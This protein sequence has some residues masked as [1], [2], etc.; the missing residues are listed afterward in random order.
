VAFNYRRF[1]GQLNT[2]DK[3]YRIL[4]IA[5]PYIEIPEQWDY[6]TIRQYDG[7]ITYNSK[8]YRDNKNRLNLKLVHGCMT[9]NSYY[10][11]EEFKS[12]EERIP[13]ACILNRSYNTG[14]E[15][16]IVYLRE[17]IANNLHHEIPVHIWSH[18]KWGGSKFKG[19][20]KSPIHHS[21]T[22]HLK[23]INEYRFCICFESSYH[24]YWSWD[25]I[26][27]RM[28]NCFKS[29][30]VPI[31]IGCYNIEQHVPKDLFID[32]RDYYDTNHRDYD[33]LSSD[34]ANF[35]RNKWE[36]MTERAFE[37]NK[38]NRIGNIEDLESTIIEFA[39]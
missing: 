37:W 25:F 14:K 10:H 22:N 4:C 31:Y 29:K 38:T 3:G 5:E 32:F 8:F 28:F 33:R 26:T 34:L 20:V 30:T 27:E 7:S 17:E 12:Y 1:D 6:N 11:L 35:P 23:K 18:V 15:S 21:H 2:R 36:D 39:I 13:G 24:E 19:V 9:C 16:D